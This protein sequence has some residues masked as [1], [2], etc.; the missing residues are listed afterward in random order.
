[1]N[2][3]DY[4]AVKNAVEMACR[5]HNHLVTLS[6]VEWIDAT[7]DSLLRKFF[8]ANNAVAK[9]ARRFGRPVVLCG[10]NRCRVHGWIDRA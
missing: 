1:M 4:K 2:R 7:L 6:L 5:S 10:E 9:T 3:M 8:V